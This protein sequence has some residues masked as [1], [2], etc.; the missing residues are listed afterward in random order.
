M[1]QINVALCESNDLVRASVSQ[2]LMD[3]GLAVYGCRDGA[4]VAQ[5]VQRVP[6]Q[7]LL[8]WDGKNAANLVDSLL[9][10]L[11]RHGEQTI[12]VQGAGLTADERLR[13]LRCG[14]DLCLSTMLEP[15]EL[16]GLLRAQVRRAA[17]ARTQE[18]A[19][20]AAMP[21]AR[22]ER[23][24]GQWALL[25]QGWVLVTPTGFGVS[26]TGIERALF[27][28]LLANP[29]RQLCRAALRE[30]M[31]DTSPRTIN[32]AISRLRRKVQDAGVRLPL[33]TV[34]G[35]GYVFVGDLIAKPAPAA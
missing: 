12:V 26:L 32:V 15:R 5:L 6:I 24:E 7:A 3:Q 13:A 22:P 11:R 29:E 16:A 27:A 18:A 14:A 35:V 30:A 31:P 9:P 28:S 21:V 2:K 20:P 8:L 33:H 10:R 17:P 34:H 1:S 4:S 23:T 25:Y 19:P